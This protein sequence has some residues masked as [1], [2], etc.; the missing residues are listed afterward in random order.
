[1]YIYNFFSDSL[2]I[3]DSEKFEEEES[4]VLP[5]KVFYLL[6]F[7]F[8]RNIHNKLIYSWWP[9]VVGIKYPKA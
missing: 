3:F 7:F 6:L 4:K 8:K 2:H 1:M 9:A 5:M